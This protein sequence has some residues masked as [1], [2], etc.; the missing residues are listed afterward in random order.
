MARQG[1]GMDLFHS[2][3]TLVKST[4]EGRAALMADNRAVM[5]HALVMHDHALR[6]LLPKY[7]GYEV[8]AMLAPVAKPGNSL[9][10]GCFGL[11]VQTSREL[12]KCAD[13]SA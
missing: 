3:V 10:C 4:V 9:L 5:I 6:S 12:P 2:G 1:K 11:S 7:C 13:A 8:P